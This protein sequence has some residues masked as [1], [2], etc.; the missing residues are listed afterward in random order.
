MMQSFFKNDAPEQ[1]EARGGIEK[2]DKGLDSVTA[3]IAAI[4]QFN[5]I[6][7]YLY[8]AKLQQMSSQGT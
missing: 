2:R 4:I 3:A 7:F 6:C 5:P 1:L 8:G